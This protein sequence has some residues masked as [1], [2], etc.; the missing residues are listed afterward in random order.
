VSTIKDATTVF[1]T[2]QPLPPDAI[3]GIMTLFRA[4]TAPNK[5][6]L[7][8]GVYQDE[9]GRTPVLECVKRAEQAVL[10][11]QDTKSY[12]AISGNAGFNRGVEQLLFGTDHAALRAG[13]VATVQVPGGSGGISVAGHLI[14]RAR[15][16]SRVHLSDPSWPNHLPLL[17]LSGL[18]LAH[19]PYYDAQAHAVDFD[20]MCASLERASPGD[21]VLIH[22]C[23]HN[24]CGADLSPAQWSELS[25]L[26]ARHEL[27]PFVDLAYQGLAEGLEQDA[28]GV[29]LLAD[30]LPEVLVVMSCSK[31]FGLYRERVGAISVIA[32]S[33]EDAKGVFSNLSNIARGIYSMPPDHGAAIV[34]RVLHD[35]E[36][37]ALWHSEL[38]V[39]RERINGLRGLLV[40]KLADRGVDHDFSFIERER[41]MF[42]FLGI[43]REQVIRL[44]EE[45]HVYMV[46]S[47]RVN[48]AGIN[49]RNV[50]YVVDAIAAV[51]KN[52]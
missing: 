51:L 14:R 42:S 6:D 4:D 10:A 21:V 30:Q 31:N 27:V 5:V 9:S 12:V 28:Y 47:S 25:E 11:G 49:G 8:V 22:G 24:P 2:L 32:R 23:C 48:V 1:E 41:G 3:L 37:T 29:R 26:L 44:R 38:G 35:P 46:E 20:A 40:T 19:Y 34:D 18:E 50:D 33:A 36:L 16:A 15:A 45:F 13:R 17:K 43:S 7:S 52:G 39:M